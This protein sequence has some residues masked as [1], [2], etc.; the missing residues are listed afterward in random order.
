MTKSLLFDLHFTDTEVVA[1]SLRGRD[2]L[3]AA[4][5]T[6]RRMQTLYR[7]AVESGLHVRFENAAVRDLVAATE[8]ICGT[9]QLWNKMMKQE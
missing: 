3:A 5:I 9:A 8:P 4:N 6:S 1:L 7:Q 2:F